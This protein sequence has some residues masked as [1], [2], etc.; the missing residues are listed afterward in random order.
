MYLRTYPLQ[1]MWVDKTLKSPDSENPSTSN[2]ANELKHSSK[3]NGGTFTI[4]IDPH[5]GN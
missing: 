1:R 4:S 3:L 5:E 2:M